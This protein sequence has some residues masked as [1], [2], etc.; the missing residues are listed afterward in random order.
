MTT[1][2]SVRPAVLGDLPA[3]RQLIGDSVRGLSAGYYSAEQVERAL[4]H[5]FGPDTQLIADGTYYVI[6]VDGELAAA[7]GWSRRRTLFGGDQMK[8]VEDP[9]LDPATE[10]ARIRAFFVHPA[11]ARRGL[12]RR[13]F[14]ECLA[15]ARSA[16]FQTLELAATLPGEPLYTS[17]GFTV[18]ERLAVSMPG[19]VELPLARMR[20]R[21]DR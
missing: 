3:L 21:I 4:V 18:V 7:G 5:V 17:L 9:L 20:Y 11:Y 12:G 13:V 1:A 2:S 8:D 14:E 10:P 6:E 15:A 16:G 19:G